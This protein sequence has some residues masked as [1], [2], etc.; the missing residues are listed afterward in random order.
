[1]PSWFFYTANTTG[2]KDP[3][4]YCL[5]WAICSLAKHVV[6]AFLDRHTARAIK[7]TGTHFQPYLQT[8]LPHTTLQFRSGEADE[9][10]RAGASQSVWQWHGARGD[11]GEVGRLWPLPFSSL[12]LSLSCSL[13]T[14]V[15]LCW[16]PAGPVA[17]CGCSCLV[18]IR[19]SH[20]TTAP[21]HYKEGQWDALCLLS[22]HLP[23]LLLSL[24][25]FSCP[26]L[27]KKCQWSGQRRDRLEFTLVYSC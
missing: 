25:L 18:V 4:D 19:S 21:S 9:A 20:C 11:W 26:F 1:M 8:R 7:G 14:L 5:V 15:G 10:D 22:L 24:S 27:G 3:F 23:L 17:P 2:L 12:C 6:P 13:S 16:G